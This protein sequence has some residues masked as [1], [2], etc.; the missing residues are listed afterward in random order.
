MVVFYTV[1][2]DSPGLK[3]THCQYNKYL[4]EPEGKTQR[5]CLSPTN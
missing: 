4:A 2:L 5:K 3:L 1:K